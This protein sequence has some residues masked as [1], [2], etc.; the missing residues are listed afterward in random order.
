MFLILF[1]KSLKTITIFLNKK[2][3]SRNDWFIQLSN[4]FSITDIEI[5]QRYNYNYTL[6]E[7]SV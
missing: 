2:I 3:T 4:F 7:K 6:F 1:L 5:F